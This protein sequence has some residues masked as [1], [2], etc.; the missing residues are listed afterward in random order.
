MGQSIKCQHTQ[1]A[2]FPG[3]LHLQYLN[4]YRI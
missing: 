2:S 4:T 1:L 3:I